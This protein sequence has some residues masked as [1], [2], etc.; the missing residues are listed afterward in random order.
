MH[1]RRFSHASILSS[2]NSTVP[3]SQIQDERANTISTYHM[4]ILEQIKFK[5]QKGKLEVSMK[6]TE[7][8]ATR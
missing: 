4:A 2:R 6:G 7:P 3:D 8:L 1:S 5:S